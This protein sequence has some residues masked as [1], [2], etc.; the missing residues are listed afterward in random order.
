MQ[1]QCV[2]SNQSV[3]TEKNGSKGKPFFQPKPTVNQPGDRYEQEA[4]AVAEQV[5]YAGSEASG[6]VPGSTMPGSLQRKCQH[7]EDDA[8]NMQ[9]KE[10]SHQTPRV[11]AGNEAYINSLGSKGSPLSTA[12]KHFFEPRIG[13]DLSDVRLHT[14]AEAAASAKDVNALAYTHGDNIVFGEGQY[15]PGTNTGTRL[16]AHELTHTLQQKGGSGLQRVQRKK[17]APTQPVSGETNQSV[18]ETISNAPAQYNDWNKS[19]TWSSKFQVVY[20]P[21]TERATIVSRLF[22]T[23]AATIKQG[24]ETAIED[25]WGKGQFEIEIWQDCLPKV[26]PV[27][28]D[29]QWVT[30]AAKA[31][32][33]I[34]ANAPGTKLDGREGNGGTAGMTVWGETDRTDI[35]HEYGHMLGNPEE[36]FTTNGTDYTHGGAD[37]GFRD[38]GRGIMNNPSESPEPRHY[39]MVREAFIS[40]MSLSP[41]I[42]RVVKHGSKNA[43]IIICGPQ[44]KGDAAMA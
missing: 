6:Y 35:T 42:V 11:S 3:I 27:D 17:A 38:T 34:T 5:M 36:Y 15:Q 16:M 21:G 12:E 20:D 10:D 29:V 13:Y 18:T 7:C 19:F 2:L 41:D 4:D 14:G 25:R 33:T 26:V 39:A 8:K 31:H 43:P 1:K 30:D 28:V 23:A 32:Y 9:R 37:Q 22:S 40:M 44:P 24:W